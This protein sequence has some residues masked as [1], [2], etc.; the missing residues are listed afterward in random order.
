LLGLRIIASKPYQGL[1]KLNAYR[2]SEQPVILYQSPEPDVLAASA[3]LLCLISLAIL[4]YLGYGYDQLSPVFFK[5][6]GERIFYVL[7][8]NAL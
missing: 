2:S 3:S 1:F 5:V 4:M 8:P 7:S 6:P